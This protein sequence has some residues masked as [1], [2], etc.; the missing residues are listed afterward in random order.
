[1]I[2]LIV[3]FILPGGLVI[4]FE[5]LIVDVLSIKLIFGYYLEESVF[6]NLETSN[7]SLTARIED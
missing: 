7:Q 1:M 5:K 6:K 4:L 3:Y 2:P